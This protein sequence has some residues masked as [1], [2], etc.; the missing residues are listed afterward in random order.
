MAA[1]GGAIQVDRIMILACGSFTGRMSVNEQ[2]LSGKH[3]FL[4]S[5]FA[6][7][8]F[9]AP[10]G[11]TRAV[12]CSQ[13]EMSRVYRHIALPQNTRQHP[14]TRTF[15]APAKL[16]VD[17]KQSQ[18][19]DRRHI[20]ACPGPLIAVRR[21]GWR[22]TVPVT[23]GKREMQPEAFAQGAQDKNHGGNR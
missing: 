18:M 11:R 22:V 1:T 13:R 5:L 9:T 21:F 6:N 23:G 8:E 17:K 10:A 20:S 4:K 19:Q 15:I 12:S 7:Y 2:G 14:L 16:N 3:R